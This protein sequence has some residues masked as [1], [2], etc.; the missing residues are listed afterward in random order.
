MVWV[1][2]HLNEFLTDDCGRVY[3]FSLYISHSSC[4]LSDAPCVS[5][6]PSAVHALDACNC[7]HGVFLVGDDVCVQAL[8]KPGVKH[9]EGGYG[10]IIAVNDGV[11]IICIRCIQN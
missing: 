1:R 5:E 2:A 3:D 10:S 11:Y 7:S 4:C 6:S 8:S 9:R